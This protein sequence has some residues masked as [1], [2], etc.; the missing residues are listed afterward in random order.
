MIALDTMGTFIA[1]HHG[2]V[3]AT[4]AVVST[5][6]ASAALAVSARTFLVQARAI[7]ATNF[8]DVRQRLGAAMRAVRS[9]GSDAAQEEFEW[10]ELLNL[11][12]ALAELYRW[13]RFGRVTRS[14]V[15]SDLIGALHMIES[16]PAAKKRLIEAFT[17]PSAFSAL[18][19]FQKKYRKEI[20]RY[21]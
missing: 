13:K 4:A 21:V 15:K 11:L 3:A 14:S 19:W 8:L 16:T 2:T 5:V 7:D 1:D 20:C 9:A 12:E 10:I 17:H 6:L 18:R